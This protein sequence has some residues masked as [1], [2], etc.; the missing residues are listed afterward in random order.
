M[1]CSYL[2]ARSSAWCRLVPRPVSCHCFNSF[3]LDRHGLLVSQ[4]L[5][6][7]SGGVG[8]CEM[9]TS[10]RLSGPA[11]PDPSLKRVVSQSEAAWQ[12]LVT[13]PNMSETCYRSVSGRVAAES[14]TSTCT[15]SAYYRLFMVARGPVLPNLLEVPPRR[16]RAR[17]ARSSAGGKGES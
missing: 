5:L 14:A 10:V 12:P 7:G 11:Y 6:F 17:C 4:V 3:R 1:N 9:G 2:P 8:V 16:R 15:V 13:H